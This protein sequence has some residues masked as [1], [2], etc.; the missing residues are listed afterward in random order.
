MYLATIWVDFGLKSSAARIPCAMAS[1]VFLQQ[2]KAAFLTHVLSSQDTMSLEE[3][4]SDGVR[5]VHLY[6]SLKPSSWR[7]SGDS[8]KQSRDYV[9]SG[10]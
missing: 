6:A 5:L 9:R 10:D 8:C 1:G 2:Q 3:E 4:S 7:Y